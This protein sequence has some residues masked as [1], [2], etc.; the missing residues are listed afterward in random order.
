MIIL[1]LR[2]LEMNLDVLPN[3]SVERT[4]LA[5]T[6]YETLLDAILSGQIPA[7]QTLNSV[8]L[9]T[10]LEVSRTPVQEAI[11]RLA[12]D[13]LVEISIGKKA[14]VCSFTSED[15]R[16]I[17]EIREILEGASAK[18][19]A[20]EL[21]E[22]ELSDLRKRANR[23]I[24]MENEKDWSARMIDF[25]IHF[26]SVLASACNNQRLQK[27]I[28]SYRLFVRRF[29]HMTGS[30]ENLKNAFQE[31]LK[32]LSALEK[33]DSASAERAMIEHIQKRLKSVL[34]AVSE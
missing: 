19:A 29:C 12:S 15:I 33:R 13:G 6:V 22:K 5:D 25:D 17:Y 9:A 28:E 16:E 31:H 18:I 21:S 3:L 4:S 34:E 32:I 10:Q 11:R 8:E 7:S 26:H 2:G 24:E 20:Q 30:K 1:N 14:Q 27:E 23:L